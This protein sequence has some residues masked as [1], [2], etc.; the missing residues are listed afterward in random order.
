VR[1]VADAL[2]YAH[3][4]GVIHRDIKP[5]NILLA[6]GH[7]L[8]AD[9]GIARAI[10]AAGRGELTT[11]G[12]AVGTPS[13]MSPEQAS[14]Q[15]DLDGRSDLY[16]LACVTYEMLAGEPPFTGR[17]AQAIA[18]RHLHEPPPALRV[19]R[20]SLPPELQ[21][22]IE[23]ALAKVRADRYPTMSR[24]VAALEGARAGRGMGRR[25]IQV[26]IGSAAMTA[27][28]VGGALW[29]YQTEGATLDRNKVVVFPLVEIPAERR[30]EGTG[31]VST[32]SPSCIGQRC[33]LTVVSAP[34]PDITKRIACRLCRWAR[35]VSPGSKVCSPPD[36]LVVVATRPPKAGCVSNNTRRSASSIATSRAARSTRG[37][38]SDQAQ[39]I[40]A[41]GACGSR[42]VIRW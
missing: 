32:R 23:T 40:G 8:V 38:M 5:G 14:G 9:F 15:D 24:F 36:R 25:R 34:E 35:A 18:A 26:A 28:F 42:V 6:G 22:V 30:L 12:I 4:R 31:E 10:T 19:V 2:A 39:A 17:T 27:V 21:R 3:G 37:S 29:R 1:E 7:A 20:P 41:S 16:S 13:Y 33:W 11:R